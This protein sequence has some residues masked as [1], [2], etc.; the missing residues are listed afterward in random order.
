MIRVAAFTA[1]RND[2][3]SRFRMRQFFEPLRQLGI[4][5]VEFRPWIGKYARAPLQLTGLGLLSRALSSVA[6]RNYDVAWL[7]R[8]FVT[9]F[10]TIERFAG[11]RRLLDVDDAIWL[12]GRGDFA[13]RIAKHC[14]GVIAGNEYIAEYFRDSTERVWI[15][16]TAVDTNRWTPAMER[17]RTFTIGWSGTAWNFPYLYGIESA[18]ARFLGGHPQAKLLVVSDQPPRFHALP[19]SR[20]EFQQWTPETEVDA[21]RRMDV[22]IM[23][24]QDDEWTRAKCAMK[25]LCYMSVGLPVVVSPIGVA[26]EILGRGA[27]GLAA[28]S[29]DEW[30]QA[31]AA[32]YHDRER[33]AA[34]GR[35]GR[36]VVDEHYS[37]RGAATQLAA[38]FTE[39]APQ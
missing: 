16:P 36:G 26:G 10:E 6:A 5:T 17:P 32:L 7:N 4:A 2:P 31:L 18:L 29:A 21:L 15:V 22:G 34:M 8:E 38:I 19:A 23:P 27:L 14:Q 1:S 9:G 20:F 30:V 39:V 37:V 11:R 33:A 12:N 3:S 24:L 28:S 35:V 25:M 13:R